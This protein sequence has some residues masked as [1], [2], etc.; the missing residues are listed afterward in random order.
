MNK[1]STTNALL[2]YLFNETQ[3]AE[4]V[5]IQLAIDYDAET[6]Q[7]FED[8]KATFSLMDK[9]L[10]APSEECVNSILAYSRA[11]AVEVC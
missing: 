2:L 10:E 3:M 1:N 5:L 6:E 11:S 8:I 7:E 9:L 4:S